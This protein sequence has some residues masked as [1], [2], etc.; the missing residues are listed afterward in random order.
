MSA[1]EQTLALFSGVAGVLALASLA[2]YALHQSFGS[3]PVVVNL[4]ARIKALKTA[5]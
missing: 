2:G 4:N 1:H 5:A 3:T